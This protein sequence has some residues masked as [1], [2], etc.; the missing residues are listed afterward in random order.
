MAKP[1]KN[2]SKGKNKKLLIAGAVIVLILLA[3]F[4][5]P[6]LFM[7]TGW[8]YDNQVKNWQ[9]PKFAKVS[10]CPEPLLSYS[11]VDTSLMSIFLYPGQ[12]RGT[13]Y[14]AHG[15]F[16][17]RQ[18]QANIVLPLNAKLTA[19]AKYTEGGDTQYLL[20][21]RNDCGIAVRFDH[22]YKLSPAMEKYLKKVPMATDGS[23]RTTPLSS[24]VLPA[25]TPVAT[26]VGL[27]SLGNKGFDFGLYDLRKT[28]EISKNPAWA[29]VEIHKNYWEQHAYGVCWLSLLPAA[30]AQRVAAREAILGKEPNPA[31]R[32]KSEAAISDYCPNAK[33]TTLD[34]NNGQP[35]ANPRW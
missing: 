22:L 26:E 27:P 24:D 30:D 35:P 5:L 16:G 6:K 28:N 11:P 14:K 25:G 10:T 3:S 23:T 31:D 34:H 4:V 29:A 1:T 20:D 18:N 15:G 12:Y 21:F 8:H 2:T 33:S 19:A 7:A 32:T 17:L 13:D 9:S